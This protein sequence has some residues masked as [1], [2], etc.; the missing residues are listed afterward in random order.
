MNVGLVLS[1]GIAKGAYQVGMLKAFRECLPANFFSC[2]STSS[3]GAINGYAYLTDQLDR[4]E[5][6]WRSVN[7]D[8]IIGFI[9]NFSKSSNVD[10][11]V[12][13]LEYVD[14]SSDVPF[15]TTLLS[16]PHLRLTYKNLSSVPPEMHFDY[17]RASIAFPPV[18][19]PHMVDNVR[20][21]D[22][23]MVDN[24]PTLPL[25]SRHI[26]LA[27]VVYFDKDNYVFENPEFDSKV[28]RVAFPEK[29]LIHD[30]FSF[31]EKTIVPMLET[32]YEAAR[33]LVSRYGLNDQPDIG[34]IYALIEEDNKARPKQVPRITGDI[35]FNR[36]TL[37]TKKL[38]RYKVLE[39]G[40]EE[41]KPSVQID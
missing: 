39:E 10:S 19:K 38:V 25:V 6:K 30:T 12:S 3:I 31:T 26:D 22:G 9:R 27:I 41:N 13:H 34:R 20:Y 23:A 8:G 15:Y 37:F 1:G 40:Q 36:F 21:I 24:I 5:E 17:L 14:L 11:I 4:A 29:K 28:I 7:S 32:G 35:L 2:I 16:V 18:I 33:E